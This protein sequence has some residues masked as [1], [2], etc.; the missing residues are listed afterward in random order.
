MFF[1]KMKLSIWF[2]L[3]S[4][5]QGKN[6]VKG[7]VYESCEIFC[8]NVEQVKLWIQEPIVFYELGLNVLQ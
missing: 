8:M 4:Y 3:F 5:P 2:C 7:L 6:E 1:K